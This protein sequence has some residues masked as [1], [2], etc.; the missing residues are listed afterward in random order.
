MGLFA[1]LDIASSFWPRLVGALV[2]GALVFA[3][4][5]SSRLINQEMK[6]E[7]KQITSLFEHAL[8][9]QAQSHSQQSHR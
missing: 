1:A 2:V 7:A 3:P 4:G 8:K 9:A 6:S 5:P